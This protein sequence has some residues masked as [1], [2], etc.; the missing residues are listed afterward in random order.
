MNER[1]PIVKCD[2]CRG[3]LKGR[4]KERQGILAAR[5]VRI[6]GISHLPSVGS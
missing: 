3:S 5:G 6:I 1:I 2:D 4:T